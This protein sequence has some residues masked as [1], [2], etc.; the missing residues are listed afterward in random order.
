MTGQ[1][2]ISPYTDF[3][4]KYIFGSE[5]NKEYLISFLNALFEGRHNIKDVTYQN[6][7]HL[8]EVVYSRRAIFDVYCTTDKGDHIIV[9]M[10]NVD[11]DYFADRMVY[12]STFPIREQAKR[13][14]W[15]YKLNPV[16]T[17]GILNFIF[18]KSSDDVHHEA[19]LMNVATKE[20]FYDKLS[21][22]TIELPKFNKKEDELVTLYD[23]WLFV[24][25][26]L[27]RLMER[28]AALQERVFASLFRHAEIDKMQPNE[29]RQYEK[30]LFDYNDINNS[31]VK[32][33]R[34][35]K[36][37]GLRE[38]K[39][40]GLREGKEEGLREG[41]EK[42][43]LQVAKNMK[44]AGVD[45]AVILATTGLNEDKLNSL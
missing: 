19:K 41:L 35:G 36:E 30:S 33:F 31:N 34:E 25:R 18:D 15:D 45:D 26:N 10:Q 37:E 20:V 44:A 12:Y 22:I 29:R 23:K 14:D 24:L 17:I 28:P 13:G 7:E 32:H 40:E 3:G 9:E 42:G 43:I 6:S 11:Q 27:S 16:Y 38:G 2:Y 39:E 1:R 4:F 21:F 5:L 8:N